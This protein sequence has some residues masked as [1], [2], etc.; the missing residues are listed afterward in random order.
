[1]SERFEHHHDLSTPPTAVRWDLGERPEARLSREKTCAVRV[2]Q[3]VFGIAESYVRGL[4]P[5]QRLTPVPGTPPH[6]LGVTALDGAI[7]PVVDIRSE[8]GESP[9]PRLETALL[10]EAAG[11]TVLLA[12]D[13]VLAFAVPDAVAGGSDHVPPAPASASDAP[14]D[15]PEA[16]ADPPEAPAEAPSMAPSAPFPTPPPLSSPPLPPAPPP[17]LPS[18]EDPRR[19]TTGSTPMLG[20]PVEL[21]DLP[22]LLKAL[23]PD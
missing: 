18:T 5:L 21:L 6:V 1:M 14:A 15:P 22:A 23:R 20:R 17:P 11:F 8:L 10:V 13:D 16:P 4:R 2:G 7:V 3:R 9:A 19:W 12:V